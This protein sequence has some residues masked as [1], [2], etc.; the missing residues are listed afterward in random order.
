MFMIA[1]GPEPGAWARERADGK[2]AVMAAAAVMRRRLRRECIRE[3]HQLGETPVERISGRDASPDDRVFHG[4]G[5]ITFGAALLAR[6]HHR[7]DLRGDRGGN[8]GR[9]QEGREHGRHAHKSQELINGKHRPSPPKKAIAVPAL[10]RPL[11][12]HLLAGQKLVAIG[13]PGDREQRENGDNGQRL[14][15]SDGR[16]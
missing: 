4:A 7:I 2:P 11:R 5:E 6:Y 16:F 13:R 9:D 8:L 15:R 3:F 12:G 10:V 14:H 1:L